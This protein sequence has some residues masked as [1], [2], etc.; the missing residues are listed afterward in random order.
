VQI[1][2]ESYRLT[3]KRKAGHAAR[4][5]TTNPE[6]ALAEARKIPGPN[7]GPNVTYAARKASKMGLGF[8]VNFSPSVMAI[9]ACSLATA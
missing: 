2:G 4:R 6:K 1:S 5:V 9:T 7:L 8:I 3:D